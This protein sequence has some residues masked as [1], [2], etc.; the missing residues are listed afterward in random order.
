[1]KSGHLGERQVRL[2]SDQP[3]KLICVV[4]GGAGCRL[5]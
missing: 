4:E 3:L 1:M 5:V 2:Q